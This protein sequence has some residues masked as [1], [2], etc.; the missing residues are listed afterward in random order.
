MTEFPPIC[1]VVHSFTILWHLSSPWRRFNLSP[2]LQILFQVFH[3]ISC[4]K[5]AF[6]P[7]VS[8]LHFSFRHLFPLA[9]CYLLVLA[10]WETLNCHFLGMVSM[11][12]VTADPQHISPHPRARWGT[13]S[14]LNL[15]FTQVL[16]SFVTLSISF[17]NFYCIFLRW[18]GHIQI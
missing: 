17:L 5:L 18:S 9:Q 1:P 8:F 12:L 7:P 2:F 10:L 4:H 6:C 11:P 16:I 14:V 15:F 3:S 13:F